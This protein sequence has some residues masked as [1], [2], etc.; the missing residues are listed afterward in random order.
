[1]TT[2]VIV[3][4]AALVVWLFWP[5]KRTT[6]TATPEV[7]VRFEMSGKATS[8]SPRQ[9]AEN[10][11]AL[12]AAG[13]GAWVLNPNSPLPLTA[14]GVDQAVAHALRELLNTVTSWSSKLPDIAYLIAWHNLRFKEVD[15]F[16]AQHRA[17]FNAEVQRL[18]RES[19]E[20]A[21]A[22]DKDKLDLL[23][24][25]RDTAIKSLGV[26]TGNA[27]LHLLLTGEP[28]NL[29]ADDALLARFAGDSTLYSFYLSQLGRANSVVAVKSDDYF[30]K[31][32]ETLVEKGLARRGKDIPKADLLESLRL[33][34]LNAVLQ[35]ATPK[36]IGRKAKAVEACMTLPDLDARLSQHISFRETFQVVPPPDMDVE[37]LAAAFSYATTVAQ[38]VQTTFYTGTR[39]LEAIREKKESGPGGYDAWEVTNWTEPVPPCAS[40][41]V[42]K[43]G[44]LPAKRPPYHVGCDCTLECSFKDD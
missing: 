1:M 12:A 26:H 18:M 19:S 23:G 20:W 39:T 27:D 25:F 3:L 34:D 17:R 30:R 7:T 15:E 28:K 6:A 32:W 35:G 31:S 5:R 4:V 2:V 37:A 8:S 38:V 36:P 24:E 11:G 14:V 13:E 40:Q 29:A 43:Y 41:F 10:I 42:K 16:V 9:G 33:K 44:R 21:S 22:S